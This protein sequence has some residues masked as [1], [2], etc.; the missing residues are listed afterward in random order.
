MK[1][2]KTLAGLTALLMTAGLASCGSTE[3]TPTETTVTTTTAA[4]VELN[5]AVLNEEDQAT[6]DDVT[7]KL[8]DVE[9]ENK[10]VKW[11]AHYD[12]NPNT[13]QG[14]SES[15]ELN[16]FRTKYGGEIQYYPTTWN[17]R[18]S[19]L[20]TYVLGGEGIDFFPAD[21]AA[22]PK[23]IIS[24][25]FQPIDDYID[26]NDEL[27]SNVSEGMEIFNFNGKHYQFVTGITAEQVC[28]YSA[29]TIDE[30]GLDDPYELWKDGDWNWDSFE[31]L[32]V[33][34]IEADP[35]DHYGLDNWF[36]EK[37]LFLSAGVPFVTTDESGTLV[38]N[39]LDPTIEKAMDF[40]YDLNQKG[41]VLDLGMFD[42]NIQ[43][44]FMG[45]GRELFNI[46]G[47][48]DIQS[49]PEVWATGIAPDDLRMVPVPSPK[50]SDPYQSATVNGWCLCKGADNPLGVALYSECVILAGTDEEANA[51]GEQKLR[52]DY[53]WTDHLIETNK[54]IN[55][56]ANEYPVV[57]LATGVS[58]DVASLTTD[59]GSEIGLR[60]AFHGIPWSTNREEIG[61]VV[62]MLVKEADEQIKSM[63]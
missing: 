16:M 21:T 11:L 28:F 37:A 41:L 60:A 17:T 22:L 42:W 34:F 46:V 54:E 39:V 59:G 50:G 63:G 53:G 20:S 26:I 1:I 3:P 23:G 55:K 12:I 15:V 43:P 13:T 49:N 61:E 35:D 31:R 9:L 51:I 25:M 40:Q 38:T 19:D 30:N 62:D 6:L 56:L 10:T 4:T 47:A 24:G 57:D 45:E 52:D 7:S 18:Y 8:R 2:R 44:Q 58:T 36:N 14:G 5:T 27:W 32:L 29:K 33:E 48:W